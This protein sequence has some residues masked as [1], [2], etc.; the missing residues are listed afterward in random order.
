MKF[1]DVIVKII[2]PLLAIL[3][4]VWGIYQYRISKENDYRNTLYK[5]QYDIYSELLNVTETLPLHLLIV[6]LPK[7]LKNLYSSLIIYILAECI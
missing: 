2:T 3:G 1:I 5:Q 4:F 7:N 6:R